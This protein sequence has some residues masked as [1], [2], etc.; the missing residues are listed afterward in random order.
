MEF[1]FIRD[2]VS[3]DEVSNDS[4]AIKINF[5]NRLFSGKE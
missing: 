3:A 4:S 1:W 5:A 2:G